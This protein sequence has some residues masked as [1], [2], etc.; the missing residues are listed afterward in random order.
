MTFFSFSCKS[1]I[2]KFFE[3]PV[4][5]H[6]FLTSYKEASNIYKYKNDTH[7]FVFPLDFIRKPA[8]IPLDFHKIVPYRGLFGTLATI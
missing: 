3:R 1:E 7:I 2:R 4:I 6:P 8:I 5:S